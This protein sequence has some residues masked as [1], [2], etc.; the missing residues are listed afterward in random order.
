MT[1][2]ESF[3]VS[4]RQV[5]KSLNET[6]NFKS[7]EGIRNE[8]EETNFDAFK[9]QFASTNFALLNCGYHTANL[10]KI[11]DTRKVIHDRLYQMSGL[12]ST[13]QYPADTVDSA[14]GVI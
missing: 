14:S 3:L 13:R 1:F 5:F 2:W 11:S 10:S 12:V 4:K 6:T 7:F 9:F 8:K